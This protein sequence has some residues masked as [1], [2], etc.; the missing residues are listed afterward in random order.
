MSTISHMQQEL[1][2]LESTATCAACPGWYTTAGMS[3]WTQTLLNLSS[4]DYLGLASDQGLAPNEFLRTLTPDTFC[5]PLSSRLLTGQLHR[6][7]RAGS[8]T[9]TPFRHGS[10]TGVQQR[11][12]CQHGHPA[13]RKRCTD[14]DTC[15]QARPCQ[16][17]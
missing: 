4:N 14:A 2:L 8:R 6:L 10:R 13:R 1:Q 7:R 16:P 5:P 17:D 12:S 11:V 9:G 15:R 3:S